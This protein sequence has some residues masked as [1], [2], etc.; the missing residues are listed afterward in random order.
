MSNGNG[1]SDSSRVSIDIIDNGEGWAFF[2]PG[3]APPP[4]DSLPDYLNDSL[5]KWMQAHP[6][7]TVKATLGL[8]SKGSTCGIH[9]W[10]SVG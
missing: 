1:S 8:V 10:Y 3:Q 6:K 7:R 5:L 9:V 2:G 4:T